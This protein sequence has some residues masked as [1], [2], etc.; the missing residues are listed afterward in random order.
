MDDV[1]Y[2]DESYLKTFDH[3]IVE[4]FRQQLEAMKTIETGTIEWDYAWQGL[5]A[6]KRYAEMKKGY[7]TRNP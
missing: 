4:C 7:E 2:D 5:L 1:I 6:Y 3:H